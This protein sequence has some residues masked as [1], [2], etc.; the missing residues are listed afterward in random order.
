VRMIQ[1]RLETDIAPRKITWKIAE[2][3]P[4]WGDPV[5]LQQV[6]LNL[7]SN[8]VKFTRHRKRAVIEIGTRIEADETVVMVR[9]NGVGFD[10]KDRNK[11]FGLFQRLHDREAF[12]GSGVGLAHV[13]R[14]VAKH[15]GRTWAEGEPGKGAAFYFS[16]PAR[17][18]AAPRDAG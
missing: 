18:A 15:G 4:L 10:M 12:E 8:A 16:L 6:M 1:A 13:R 9:D 3:Q 11:L 17:P 2:C 5:M 14:I 7:V